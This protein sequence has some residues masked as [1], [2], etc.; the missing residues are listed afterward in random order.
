MRL[1]LVIAAMALLA[2]ALAVAQPPSRLVVGELFT[3]EGCSSCPPADAEIAALAR[4]RPDLLLLTFHVT[5]WNSLGW[6]DPFSFEVATQRQRRYVALGVSPEVYTPALIVDGE[7]DAVGSDPAAVERTLNK[8]AL[9]AQTATSIELQR[10]PAGLTV[11]VGAGTG[12]GTLLLISYDRLHRTH[13]GRSIEPIA[14][15]SGQPARLLVPGPAGEEVAAILQRD[16]GRIVG[17]GV[18]SPR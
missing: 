9:Q 4:T 11:S 12:R 16:D 18:A 5:Y 2:P 3:S 17:A 7:R 1:S 14:A 6:Q 10:G 13:V 15:W 8:A